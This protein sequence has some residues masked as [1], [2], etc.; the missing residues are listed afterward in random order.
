MSPNQEKNANEEVQQLAVQNLQIQAL[1]GEMKRMMQVKL[2][3]IHECLD[4]VK[5]AS[6]R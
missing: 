6:A 5:T 1:T 2:E 3:H 4:R